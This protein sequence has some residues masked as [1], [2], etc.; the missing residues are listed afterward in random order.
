MRTSLFLRALGFAYG[1]VAAATCQDH[2]GATP[3]FAAVHAGHSSIIVALRALGLDKEKVLENPFRHD[4]RGVRRQ[5]HA[6][7]GA[8]RD[9]EHLRN[10]V[11]ERED[12]ET[13]LWLSTE[14]QRDFKHRLQHQQ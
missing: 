14:S 1:S 5:G 8:R 12:D 11:S 3:F 6:A 7:E 2:D 13:S 9:R 4:T 10:Q